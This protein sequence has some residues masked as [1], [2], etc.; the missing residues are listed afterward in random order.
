MLTSCKNNLLAILTVSLAVTWLNADDVTMKS[1][2]TYSG[3][4]TYQDDNIVKI[5][6]PI[7][8]SI[9]ETKILDAKEVAEIKKDDPADVA[10]NELQKLVPTPSLMSAA[11]YR[12]AIETGPNSYLTKFPNSKHTEEVKKI[13]ATLE[14][15]L[16]KV[17][18]GWMQLE[19]EWISPQDKIAFENLIES[20][21]HFLKMQAFADARNYNGYISAMRE[22][23]AIETKHYG[24][25]AFPKGVELARQILPSLGRQ[26]QNM[27]RDVE[28][29]NAEFERNKAALDSV[30]RQ[31]VEAARAREE[32]NYQ[33]TLKAD[34]DAGINWV[35][36]N[37][38][39]KDSIEGYISHVKE[40][41]AKL[42]GYDVETLAAQAEKL[43]AVDKLI[44]EGNLGA[45]KTKLAEA[46]AMSGEKVTTGSKKSKSK[47]GRNSY[48]GAL[49]SKLNEQLADRAAKAEAES[50]AKKSEALTANL[51]KTTGPKAGEEEKP[52]EGEAEGEEAAKKPESASMDDFAALAAKKPSEEGAKGKEKSSKSS[53]KKKK[54]S[55]KDEDEDEDEKKE[56]RP[57]P[58]VDEG[59]G[60]NFT[61]V[62][63]IGT[64]LLVLAVVLMKVLGIGGKKE[65]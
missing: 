7:S 32:A 33:K 51:K 22:F 55:S 5:E 13:K 65:E 43:V 54:S 1:G 15:E 35:R 20:R 50:A 30:A 34:K 28:A 10:F 29:R 37:P 18:R 12:T 62:I 11:A 60:F 42:E 36:L 61:I 4:I 52:K 31:Q 57:R 17:E 59:G 25:P 24:S 41:M 53:D 63:W 49:N 64:A 39:S 26:L 27:W 46:A 47:K 21:I 6:I 23:E 45:A 2:E 38:R 44:A 58:P 56:K 48:I 9:N 16:D 19:G 8:A 14:E 3:R 40:E